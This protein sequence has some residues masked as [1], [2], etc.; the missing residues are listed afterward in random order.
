M[1]IQ[2]V[3]A[4][5]LSIPWVKMGG[6]GGGGL[7]EVTVSEQNIIY[8]KT[9]AAACSYTWWTPTCIAIV[10]WKQ[11]RGSPSHAHNIY[12]TRLA[13]RAQTFLS[14]NY[15]TLETVWSYNDMVL[16]SLVY[17]SHSYLYLGLISILSITEDCNQDDHC[18]I[19]Q[20]NHSVFVV[21]IYT[22]AFADPTVAGKFIIVQKIT[23][24]GS[25]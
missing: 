3:P 22:Q 15:I 1:V 2:F 16:S 5:F 23:C 9:S 11:L 21:C 18:Y 7:R 17:F 14:C 4:K 19:G 20:N 8:L 6:G 10:T 24:H 12:Q 25:P 13:T